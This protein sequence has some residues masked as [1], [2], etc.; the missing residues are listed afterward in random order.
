MKKG[1][2]LATVCLIPLAGCA[3]DEAL[4][5]GQMAPHLGDAVKRNILAQT[6]NPDAG[7]YETPQTMDGH[8]AALAQARYVNGKV[9]VPED[10]S[11][12]QQQQNG[13]TSGSNSSSSASG[14]S[15]P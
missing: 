11:S 4:Q 7:S 5:E 14:S 8:R 3:S 10:I 15:T 6:V 12:S 9:I 13:G 2:L 1:L